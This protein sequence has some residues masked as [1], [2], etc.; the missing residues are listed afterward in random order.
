M[1]QVRP[2]AAP[3]SRM[4]ALADEVALGTA[5]LNSERLMSAAVALRLDGA[6]RAGLKINPARIDGGGPSNVV[7]DRAVLRVNLRPDT[8][9]DQ[10]A[11]QILIDET[12]ERLGYQARHEVTLRG[13]CGDCR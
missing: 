1:E 10:E 5:L 12:V 6:K 11:A 8:P 9:A 4:A 2:L 13:T 7:P 3:D